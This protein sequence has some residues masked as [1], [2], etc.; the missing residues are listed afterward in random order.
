VDAQAQLLKGVLPVATLAVLA[1]GDSYGYRVLQELRARGLESVGDASVYGTLQRLFD[2]GL[3][4]S[5]VAASENG[6]DRRYY[7][8]TGAGA[9]ALEAGRRTWRGF[10]GVIDGL[11][12]AVGRVDADVR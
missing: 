12:D 7:S 10:A 3:L 11:L 2:E 6:P 8:L 5:Y 4:A 1:T 9:A